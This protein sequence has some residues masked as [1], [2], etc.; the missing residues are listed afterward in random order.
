[1]T[2]PFI[3]I[4]NKKIKIKHSLRKEATKVISQ[5][6]EKLILENIL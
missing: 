6:V 1:M 4:L 3:H 2:Y 5:N